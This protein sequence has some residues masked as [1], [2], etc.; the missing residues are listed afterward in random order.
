MGTFAVDLSIN[1]LASI[2]LLIL[3]AAFAISAFEGQYGL[4]FGIMFLFHWASLPFTYTA[5]YIFNHSGSAVIKMYMLY[6]FASMIFL[7]V[8]D[9]L[10]IEDLGVKEHGEALK[11]FFLLF[12]TFALPSA[13]QD[14]WENHAKLDICKTN[15]FTENYCKVNNIDYVEDFASMD[16]PGVGRHCL[17][18]FITGLFFFIFLIAIDAGWLRPF[19]LFKK[20]DPPVTLQPRAPN[21]MLPQGGDPEVA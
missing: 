10:H 12:P 19:A 11:W 9:V 2:P 7:I 20:N 13:I 5:A 3:F 8:N 18:M 16:A 14:M 21:P 4:I 1:T 6:F 17:M 15:S